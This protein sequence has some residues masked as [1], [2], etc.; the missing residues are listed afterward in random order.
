MHSDFL[1]GVGIALLLL[2]SDLVLN[3]TI[4]L[5]SILNR[6]MKAPSRMVPV[7]RMLILT[8]TDSS[9]PSQLSRPAL[10]AQT[11]HYRLLLG[12][13]V[14]FGAFCMD[15]ATYANPLIGSV[16]VVLLR[17]GQP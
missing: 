13:S 2:M 8:V 1:N 14:C 5:F 16:V 3:N 17:D 12:P 4:N 10:V 7:I 11:D 6:N 9:Q 15:F